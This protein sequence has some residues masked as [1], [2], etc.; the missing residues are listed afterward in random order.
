MR[1]SVG[2]Q[3]SYSSTLEEAVVSKA[4]GLT[5]TKK[6]LGYATQTEGGDDIADVKTTNILGFLF[7]LKFLM[8]LEEMISLN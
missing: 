3:D 7:N 4:L 8:T 2:N 5:R 6:N 1:V